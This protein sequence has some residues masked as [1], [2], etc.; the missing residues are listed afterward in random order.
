MQYDIKA[1]N[2]ELSDA[3]RSAVD[4]KMA[5]LDEVTARFGEV[6]RGEVE[7]GKTTKHHKKGPLFRAEIHVIL[8]SKVVYAEALNYDLY[9]AINDAK[10]EAERQIVEFRRELDA[11]QKRGGRQ[12]KEDAQGSGLA[13]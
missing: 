5:A 8:P 4:E 2:I 1:K 6:V 11:K 9:I 3:I 12:A 10:K 13:G 7:V